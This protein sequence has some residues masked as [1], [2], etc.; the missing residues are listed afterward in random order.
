MHHNLRSFMKALKKEKEIVEIKTE[1]DPYLEIPEIHRRVIEEQGPAL[2]FTNVKGS[3]TPVV[4][5]LFG[6]ERRVDIAFGP[7]PEAFTKQVVRALDSLLPPT[8]KALW[9]EKALFQQLRRIG[10]KEVSKQKAPIRQIETESFSLHDL[11]AVTSWPE[12]SNPFV[13]LPLVYTE[14]PN[15]KRH[16]LGMYRVE[17]REPKRGGMHWQIQRGGGF[18]HYEA[19]KKN[20]PLPTTLFIGGPPALI[21]TAIAPLPENIPEL[22]LASLL[23]DDKLPLTK[24]KDYPHPLI[25]E[26]EFA[27]GGVVPPHVR[28]PEGP[29]GDHYGY[30]SL[31]HDFP[32]FDIKKMWRRKDAIYPATIVGK[33]R[34][35][36]Y[37]I[38]EYLQRLLSPFFPVVMSGVH[39]LWTY[40]ET[41]FH[42]LAGAVV[43]ESYYKEGLAHALAIMGQGQLTLT[44]F[45]MVT[46]KVID[47]SDARQLFEAVLERFRPERDLLIMND[48][49]MDTL[50]YTGRSFNVGS[51]AIMTGLGEPVRTLTRTYLGG[52]IPG[53]SKVKP[54]CGG[55]LVISGSS[56]EEDEK[57]AERLVDIAKEQLVD[58][59][60]V[61]LVDDADIADSQISFL[62]TTFTR[63]DPSHDLYAEAD[64]VRNNIRYQGPLII[65]ARM[66]P[67]YPKEV[68]PDPDTVKLV[69]EKWKKYKIKMK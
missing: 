8:P 16:N 41:G 13:T 15:T 67:F 48:T 9:K 38:G 55:C 56:Y 37:Y 4:T 30:Y 6:T 18:H 23:L 35:E 46:N 3:K 44:K 66:K 12:D 68:E 26:A 40:G 58:W 22:V 25:A 20:E 5:N 14:D 62:W 7:K 1:V 69:D 53:I 36:D 64:I 45:L 47:L 33:P 52:N 17:I 63:F 31:K 19:E 2:F 54:F 51:K 10:M 21:V 39:S 60:M 57:L 49:S 32:V 42:S 27:F 50:D 29:F 28:E 65:D 34:Q 43:R 61:F 59:Q 24:V 11:P